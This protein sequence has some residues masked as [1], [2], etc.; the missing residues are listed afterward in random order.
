[1]ARWGCFGFVLWGRLQGQSEER[2]EVQAW[3]TVRVREMVKK[4]EKQAGQS[5]EG[6]LHNGAGDH[7]KSLGALGTH[8]RCARKLTRGFE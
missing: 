8:S 3:S 7:S 5:G 6:C 4:S 2:P 1:M